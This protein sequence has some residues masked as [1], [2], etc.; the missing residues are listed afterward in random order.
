MKLNTPD[1]LLLVCLLLPAIQAQPAFAGPVE[2]QAQALPEPQ[3]FAPGIVSAAA[4]DGSPTFSPDGNLL[5]FTR[6]T[7]NWGAI[8][9][10]H[11][12]GG[13]WSKPELASFS[14]EWPDSSPSMSPDGAPAAGPA[15]PRS[16]VQPVARRSLRV[17]LERTDSPPRHGQHW[18]L[19]LETEH[20]GERQPLFHRH[21]R[22]RTE[23]FVLVE[24]CRRRLPTRT[25]FGFQRRNHGRRG[26]R[27]CT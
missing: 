5:F 6:S 2:D 9:E 16:R 8:L 24:V 11:K 23:A 15:D 27:D 25:T 4:N 14:G 7:A 3:V 1:S 17:R 26:P 21:R 20:R 13:Q 12:A 10:S 22:Q 19:H 18:P